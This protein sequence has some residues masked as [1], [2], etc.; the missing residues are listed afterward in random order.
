[1]KRTS[2]LVALLIVPFLS[3]ITLAQNKI[4]KLIKQI[5]D[6]NDKQV[7]VAAHRGD[8][9]NAPE[10]SLKAYDFAIQ[11]GVDIIEVD[12]AMTKDSV[13]V[14][15]HD[16]TINRTTNGKGKPADFTYAE[17][18][19]FYLKNGLGRTTTH[20]IPTLEQVMNMAK[21]KVLVNLDKSLPFYKQAFNIAKATGTLQQAIFK[22]EGKY[23]E[24]KSMYPNLLDSIVFMPVVNI[25]NSD[26]KQTINTYI[27]EMK[28][29]AFEFTFK[30][31]TSSI[32]TNY[33]FIKQG[34]SKIW[35]NSLWPSL[36][37][38]H[39]DDMAVEDKNT[40][41]SWE[42]LINHGANVLQTDRPRELLD[43][44]RSR[45]LHD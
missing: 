37:G 29:V 45:K 39:A 33:K 34:G 43:Y 20:K 32:L 40:K 35:L 17:I 2:M 28:P 31:D 22:T 16:K 36:N 10:N 9:R 13:I 42:W 25:D 1:M 7:M 18:Q 3:N 14:I 19:K 15:M 23:D 41:D 4:D 24:L 11:M 21:G 44:L 5:H 38:N 6:P 30:K 26:C 27:K 12:L 8:W